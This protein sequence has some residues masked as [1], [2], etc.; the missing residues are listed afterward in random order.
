MKCSNVWSHSPYHPYFVEVGDIYIN[1][2]YPY[3]NGFHI[4]WNELSDTAE[5]VTVYYRKRDCGEYTEAGKTER[6]EFDVT[7]LTEDYEY[8]V[9][10]QSGNKKSRVRL[11]RT[12]KYVG[13]IVNY[14][15][16]EDEAY[17]FSG[18]YLCSPSLVRHP[19]G[20]LLASMDVYGPAYPQN[21]TLIYRSD[22]DGKTWH[23]VSE[24]FPCFWAKMFIHNGDLYILAASTELGDLLIGKS[25][26]GG[27]TFG[28]PTVLL[29]GSGRNRQAGVHKNPQNIMR[30]KGRIYETLKWGA[31]D[32]GYHAAMVMSC[33]ENED[34]LVAE[35]W[36][37]S[38]PVKYNRY[39]KG[40]PKGISGGNI[41]GTLTVFPDGKL[42]N[43]MRYDM[44]KL[45]PDRGLVVA[46]K[47]NDEDPDAPLEFSHTVKM[48]CNSAKFMIKKDDVSGKYYSIVSRITDEREYW[49]RNLLSLMS[50]ENMEDWKV[51]CDLY[52][53]RDKDPKYTGLQYAD[54]EI[55]GD[56]IIYLCRTALNRPNNFHDS[57]YST[58]H[59][60]KDFRNI[61]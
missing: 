30:Y 35:N 58:F 19:E 2:V 34:L 43:V 39:W 55:E 33:D 6:T 41:E 25:E 48:P 50:S 40:V 12:G 45:T 20:Y 9:F 14:L 54:F 49:C 29:R 27:K 59:R 22:D 28:T 5:P 15:H 56:D 61:K 26:D 57:N 46:Y 13:T 4:E 38:E 23:Y 42:Y 8:E 60:I 52:D 32:Q 36:H 53:F 47:V 21:L 7:G 24:L 10:V 16:P 11:L 18:H 51:E 17:S 44:S 31:G 37:L 3:E 1:R